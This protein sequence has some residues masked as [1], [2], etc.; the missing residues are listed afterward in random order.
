MLSYITRR[1]ALLD[2]VI[3]VWNSRVNYRVTGAGE[4]WDY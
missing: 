4:N 2:T 1:I 3:G